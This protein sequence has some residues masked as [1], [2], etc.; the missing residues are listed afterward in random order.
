MHNNSYVKLNCQLTSFAK[1]SIIEFVAQAS[2]LLSL[3]IRKGVD[4]S[5]LYAF[6]TYIKIYFTTKLTNFFGTTTDLTI[7]LSAK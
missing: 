7:D 1:P 3:K 6:L 4:L 2:R 5:K